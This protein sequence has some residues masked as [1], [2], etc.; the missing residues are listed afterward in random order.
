M[1]LTV[2]L[3]SS[4]AYALECSRE[5]EF[6]AD[7]SVDHLSSWKDIY[8]AYKRFKHC[9][10]GAISEGY[11]DGVAKIMANHWTGLRKARP[12]IQADPAFELWII[13][14]LDETDT[15]DERSN[16]CKP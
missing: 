2:A 14:H 10:D 9:D 3:A 1:S 8:S 12:L 7:K 15:N 13:H 6:A 5:D 11:S 4:S 16:L